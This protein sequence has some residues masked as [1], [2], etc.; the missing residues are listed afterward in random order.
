MKT[1]VRN[2]V[3]PPR[4]SQQS[5]QLQQQNMIPIEIPMN[6]MCSKKGEEHVYNEVESNVS[7]SSPKERSQFY[8]K[9]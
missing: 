5:L 7:F 1:E 8:K 3:E 9:L 2:E 4:Q 6:D